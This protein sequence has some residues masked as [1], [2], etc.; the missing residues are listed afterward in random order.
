MPLMIN[1]LADLDQ[2]LNSAGTSRLVFRG[3]ADSSWG[4]VPSLYRGLESLDVDGWDTMIGDKERDIF[5]EFSDRSLR[6]RASD[7]PW[8]VLVL[9]QHYGTPTRLLDW[10]SNAQAALYFATAS[11]PQSAGALWCASPARLPMP[12]E[13]GRIHDSL[14][15]RTERLGKFVAEGDLP[16]C[17]PDSKTVPLPFIAAQVAPAPPLPPFDQN[18]LQDLSGILT[19]F[20]PAQTNDRVFVQS[21]LFSVYISKDSL[22]ELVIDHAEYLRAVE[23]KFQVEI[24]TKLIIPAASKENL[25]R[26]LAR[27]GVDA[28]S[29]FPDLHGLGI[30]LRGWQDKLVQEVRDNPISTWRS[31]GYVGP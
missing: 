27:V 3:Q 9:A 12:P 15:Y 10:T 31:G 14:G 25:R 13:V 19:F 29:V 23:Q 26:S 20:L 22:D 24:L 7:R 17:N 28:W 5:R 11:S 1:S 21:G 6:L 4:L 18:G 16:F 2:F 8:D 30:Y